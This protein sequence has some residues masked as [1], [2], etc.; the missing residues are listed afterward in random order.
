MS[1]FVRMVPEGDTRERLV[2]P[3]CGHISYENP[4]IVAGSVVVNSGRVLLCRRAIEPSRGLWTVPAGFL[5][6]GET[7][8][9]GAAREVMEEAQARIV[10]D[11]LLAIYSVAGVGQV[12]LFYRARFAGDPEFGPGPESQAVRLFGWNDIPWDHIAFPTVRWVLH[13]WHDG[14][15]GPVGAPATNPPEDP[16]GT[17]G[18]PVDA[19]TVETGL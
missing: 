11:G 5:E 2:C 4:K 8:K 12:Q 6:M 1:Q 9:E 13:A 10:L 14:G 15:A 7:L 18:L 19:D 3:S 16:R 17:S